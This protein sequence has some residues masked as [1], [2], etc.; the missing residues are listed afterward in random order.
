MAPVAISVDV[1]TGG[2]GVEWLVPTV[3]VTVP[4]LLLMVAVLA[5]SLGALVW[6]PVVRRWLG[7]LGDR[8]RRRRQPLTGG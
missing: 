8:G 4:G 6:I 3:A 7:G 2:I 5:Q 1:D